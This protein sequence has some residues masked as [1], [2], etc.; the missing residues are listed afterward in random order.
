VG[1][2]IYL[3]KVLIWQFFDGINAIYSW[4]YESHENTVNCIFM[5][6][7]ILRANHINNTNHINFSVR[8]VIIIVIF[9]FVYSCISEAGSV[10]F[11]SMHIEN[12]FCNHLV[13]IYVSKHHRHH[14]SK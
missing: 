14:H 4:D 12:I 3:I 13:V 5:W 2:W 6:F 8:I 1:A 10:C 9:T 7:V 11:K